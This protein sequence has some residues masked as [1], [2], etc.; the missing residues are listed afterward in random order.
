MILEVLGSSSDGNCYILQADNGET[1]IIEAG[2][3]FAEVKKALGWQL[4]N[5]AA[6]LV[7]HEHKD[8][9]KYIPDFLRCGI[10][11]LALPEVFNSQNIKNRAFCKEIKP[12]HGYKAGGFKA[13]ALPVVHDA[14]CVG[15]II[16]HEEMGKLL[17][18]TDT[19]ML[20][21][22][23]P[24]LN[25]IMLEANY[26][27]PILQDNIDGGIMPASM[28]ER[29]LNSHMELQTA[30]EILRANDLSE[31]NEIILLHLSSRNSN[32]GQFRQTISKSAGLPVHIARPGL[33]LD[34]SL[35]P[36]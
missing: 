27:D 22:R 26:S 17:F 14:P 4:E 33:R 13:F 23:L 12:M 19:M 15:F 6:C 34:L 3:R 25:H 29:L 21:F 32:P 20:E 9:A 30:A 35:N 16:E 18:L 11:V 36:Y 1:L 5:V 24:P 10:A 31:A 2:V 28:R 8:H 7:S